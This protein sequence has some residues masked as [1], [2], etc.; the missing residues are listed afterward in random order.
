MRSWYGIP[1]ILAL[2]GWGEGQEEPVRLELRCTPAVVRGKVRLRLEGSAALPEGT[3]VRMVVSRLE[4]MPGEKGFA[5]SEAVACTALAPVREGRFRAD[6][7]VETE[8]TYRVRVHV[9]QEDQFA[10]ILGDIRAWPDR[11]WRVECAAWD[12]GLPGR[13]VVALEELDSLVEEV[14]ALAG[15][16]LKVSPSKE[17]WEKVYPELDEA[18]AAL[19]R[20]SEQSPARG[21]FTAT[22]RALDTA[23]RLLKSYASFVVFG[24]DGARGLELKGSMRLRADKFQAMSF[25]SLKGD[26]ECLR[27]VAGREFAL[28]VVKDLRRAGPREALLEVV[29]IQAERPGTAPYAA[30]LESGSDLDALE[31]EIRAGAAGK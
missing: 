14:V 18:A 10:G 1:A 25:E 22:T 21:L 7:P 31:R 30:R 19:L 5:P 9:L 2:A 4:E 13:L 11:A 12:D 6:R 24:E 28:W 29:R 17:E 15:R 26:A 3:R 27:E 23:L 16:F 20:K 8:G